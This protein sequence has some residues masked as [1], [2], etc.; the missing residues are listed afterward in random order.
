MPPTASQD[1]ISK[2]YKRK[3]KA[4][5]PDKVKAQLMAEKT[6]AN[7]QGKGGGKGGG[8]AGWGKGGKKPPRV[9]R[10]PSESEVRAA[11]R[12]AS[13]R[14]TRLGLAASIL[15]GP[16][17]ERYDHFLRNGF[18]RWKGAD[19]YYSRYRPG[20]GSAAVFL[21]IVAGGGAHYL[22]LWTGWRR[23]RDFV[24]R[25]ISF[26]RR[27]AWPEGGGTVGSGI[28]GVGGDDLGSGARLPPGGAAAEDEPMV[29]TVN[30]RQRRMQE[31]ESRRDQQQQQQ[32]QQQGRKGGRSK[33]SRA[34]AAAAGDQSQET[35]DR[36]AAGPTGARKRVVA[37][38]GKVLV[39]DSLG[40]VYLEQEEDG[41]VVEYLLDVSRQKKKPLSPETPK[42]PTHGASSTPRYSDL[43]TP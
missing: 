7:K 8:K 34:A 38:N 27:A 41:R 1:D 16:G 17:R 4:L 36:P 14:Q 13:E 6:R 21:L 18:P 37:E 32:Q 9:V 43:A 33:G 22:A 12:T 15:K 23:R 19:Y 30:R 26:A 3:T 31:R 5:H 24:V 39:V 25:Y 28:P 10:Q 35:Q 29:Q 40:D 42:F 20:L 11:V 2:A